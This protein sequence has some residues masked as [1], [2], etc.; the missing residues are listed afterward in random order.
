M[1]QWNV[2]L[3]YLY[4]TWN[5]EIIWYT[6]CIKLWTHQISCP[7][8]SQFYHPLWWTRSGHKISQMGQWLTAN[9]EKT[10]DSSSVEDCG[11]SSPSSPPL[12]CAV[13]SCA[14]LSHT[15][16]VTCDNPDRGQRSWETRLIVLDNFVIW[17]PSGLQPSTLLQEPSQ[18]FLT[19]HL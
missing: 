19:T 7:L 12:R 15:E 4:I 18:D 1:K 16:I 6:D 2:L 9:L 3:L 11:S 10:H 13:R 5:T 8:P 17:T 14:W